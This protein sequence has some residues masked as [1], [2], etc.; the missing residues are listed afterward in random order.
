[1]HKA[2]RTGIAI[3]AMLLVY[4]GCTEDKEPAQPTD[5][6]TPVELTF[7]FQ[8]PDVVYEVH[9]FALHPWSA[10]GETHTGIDIVPEYLDLVGTDGLRKITIVAPADGTI[11]MSAADTSGA[12]LDSFALIMQIDTFWHLL[13]VFEPQSADDGTN[14]TQAASFDVVEGQDVKRGDKIG[15][16]VIAKVEPERYPHLHFGVFYKDP[17][18]P[19]ENV[20]ASLR[21]SDGSADSPMILDEDLGVP[22]TFYCPYDYLL[23]EGK[24]ILDG[25]PNLDVLGNECS[26]V[27]SY[28]SSAG[29]CGRCP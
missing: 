8:D 15:D 20:F 24:A 11:A 13:M 23:S 29:D 18:E 14:E 9:N 7:P 5:T 10:S 27:C 3:F 2:P 26:C 4:I 17:A 6:A 25:V 19:W 12:G 21:V 16:L 28:G 22:T 1:M